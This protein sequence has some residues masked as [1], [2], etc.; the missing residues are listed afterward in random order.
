MDRL[1]SMENF[2]RVLEDRILLRRCAMVG[3]RGRRTA[4]DDD[5]PV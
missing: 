5:I 2:I 1:A 3:K 4:A